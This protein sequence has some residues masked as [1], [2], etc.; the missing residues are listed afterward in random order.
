MRVLGVD[1]LGRG[2]YGNPMALS[3]IFPRTQAEYP[4]IARWNAEFDWRTGSIFVCDFLVNTQHRLLTENDQR[5]LAFSELV[6]TDIIEQ[7]AHAADEATASCIDCIRFMSSVVPAARTLALGQ[8]GDCYGW[9]LW[10]ISRAHDPVARMNTADYSLP[11][12]EGAPNALNEAILPFLVDWIRTAY[13]LS[14]KFG[15]LDD[16]CR[17]FFGYSNRAVVVALENGDLRAGVDAA[18]AMT[19]WATTRAHPGAQVLSRA[20]FHLAQNDTVSIEIKTRIEMLFLTQAAQ[21]TDRTPV[22]WARHLLENRRDY[23]VEHEALQAIAIATDDLP[24]WL[25]NRTDI[26]AQIRHLATSFY[27]RSP[28]AEALISLESR[29]SILMPLIYRLTRFGSVDDILDVLWAW[30]GSADWQ[31]ADS[32]ILFICPNHG[33]GVAYVWPTGRWFA[34]HADI[35]D[36][37]E[38][39]L[40]GISNALSDYFRGPLGDRIVNLDDRRVG[41]PAFENG[42]ALSAAVEAHYQLTGLAEHLPADFEPRSIVVLPGHRD[43]LQSLLRNSVGKFAAL[44]ASLAMAAADRAIEVLSVWPGATQLTE[45]EVECLHAVAETRGWRLKVRQGQLNAAAF[46]EFYEDPEADVLWTIGHGEQ[47]PYSVHESGLVM[48]EG[49]LLSMP[50]LASFSVPDAGRRLLVLNVCSSGTAQMMDGM[51]RVGLAQELCTPNQQVVAHLWPIDYHAALAFG[52]S[53]AS[54]LRT[55]PVPEAFASATTIMRRQADLLS[56]LDG[57]APGLLATERLS[58]N[59]VAEKLDNILCWGCPALFT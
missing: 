54:R 13:L 32:N 51:A 40:V 17:E 27:E 19:N 10:G 49:G 39:M 24:T 3:D 34:Q 47:S 53:M 59:H 52:C 48:D 21:W 36:S 11:P 41:I 37:L 29:I 8:M 4:D 12:Y 50:H 43:P 35:D 14:R 5:M 57:I 20:L 55:E 2:G 33:D 58:H 38:N 23:L 45:P 1:G 6:R 7:T 18:I 28:R 46:Q 31:R 25:T 16:H 56:E 42:Q 30:Y 26:L 22:D 44:E 9:V 15:G